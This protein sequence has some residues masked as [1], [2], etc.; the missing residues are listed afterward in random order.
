M[1]SPHHTQSIPRPA[2]AAARDPGDADS[3]L[4]LEDFGQ[5]PASGWK[6]FDALPIFVLLVDACALR[7]KREN[8]GD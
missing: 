5:W 7:A 8:V 2:F 6:N 3:L 1:P 4:D